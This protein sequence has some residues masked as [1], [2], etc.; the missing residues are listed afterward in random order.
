M[1]TSFLARAQQT[2]TGGAVE[3]WWR[4]LPA[5]ALVLAGWAAAS[6]CRRLVS[7]LLRGPAQRL[8]SRLEYAGSGRLGVLLGSAPTFVGRLLY[9]AVFL[10]FLAAAVEALPFA[11]TDGL[12]APVARFLPR[13]VL[14]SAVVITGFL[15]GRLAQHW[16]LAG[17]ADPR[18]ERAQGLARLAWAGILGVSLIVGA[19]QVGLEGAGFVSSLA[20]VVFGVALGAVGLAFGVGAGP[21]VTNILASHYASRAFRVGDAVRIGDIE[22]TVSRVAPTSI[23]VETDSDTVHVPARVFC[24]QASVLIGRKD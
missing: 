11:A 3:G 17:S 20:L 10:L 9:W 15:A 13:F 12:L 18:G 21:I 6:L 23:V 1:D 22:G 24:E 8:E 5:A 19:Q 16:V 7:R 14:A 2:V 4:L